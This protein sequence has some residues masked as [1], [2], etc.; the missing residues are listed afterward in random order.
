ML[1]IET[2][3]EFKFRFLGSNEIKAEEL[4]AFLT[5][6]ANL[7][8][9]IATITEND[10]DLKL[11]VTA[12]EKGSFLITLTTVLNKLPKLFENIK[13]AKEIV[14]TLKEILELKEFLKNDKIK[15]V[16]EG[17]IITN[18]GKI[19]DINYKPTFIILIDDKKRKDVDKQITRFAEKIPNRQL[20]LEDNE[21]IFEITREVKENLMTEIEYSKD[22]DIK[23]NTQIIEREL[24]I[25]KP[26]LTMKSQWEF[27]GDKVIRATIDDESFKKYVLSGNFKTFHGHKLKVQLEEKILYNS[28]LEPIDTHYRILKIY[29][30][31][32][33]ELKLL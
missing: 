1:P 13:N 33:S 29:Q 11:N 24:V 12:I 7:F 25:K 14:G 3:S 6:T 20:N 30:D 32:S 17:Q 23:I 31:F 5:E 9:K 8:D 10:I 18:N 15:E 27:V 19:R 26:D 16:Q 4:G 28:E 2:K 22:E 21:D